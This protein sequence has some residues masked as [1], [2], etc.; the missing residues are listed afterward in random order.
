MKTVEY[1]Y[2]AIA[3]V[4]KDKKTVKYY[5]SYKGTVNAGID[6]SKIDV[7]IN[8]NKKIITLELPPVE[9]Q[10]IEVAMEEMKFIFTK[11]KYETEKV[12]QEAYKACCSDLEKR[13]SEENILFDVARDNAVSSIKALFKPLIDASNEDYTIEIKYKETPAVEEEESK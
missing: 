7:S 3:Q 10:S 5:V 2:N 9:I 4:N 13:I 11:D 12:T 8:G 1:D 6:F